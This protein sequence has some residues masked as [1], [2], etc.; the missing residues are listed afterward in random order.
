MKPRFID[1][2]TEKWYKLLFL[3]FLE[4]SFEDYLFLFN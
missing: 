3:I 4:N 1:K 2:K